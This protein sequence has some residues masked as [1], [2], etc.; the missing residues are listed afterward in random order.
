MYSFE[1]YF[2]PLNKS[3]TMDLDYERII[4][5]VMQTAGV[6]KNSIRGGGA[7]KGVK[8]FAR[9]TCSNSACGHRWSSHQVHVVLNLKM[10]TLDKGRTVG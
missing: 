10:Q 3:S 2:V 7:H 5:D 6:L 9:I 1:N 4:C 8:G